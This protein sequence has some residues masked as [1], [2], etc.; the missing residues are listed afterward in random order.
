[1][2]PTPTEQLAG[3]ARILADAVAPAVTDPYAARALGGAV[4]ALRLLAEGGQ[5]LGPFL[6]WD[7][8]QTA[9]VLRLAG[10][11]VEPVPP[12]PLADDELEAH[13]HRLREALEQAL[14]S[15]A[16]DEAAH[17]ALV[18]LFRERAARWPL[19]ARR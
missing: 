16:S 1:M 14:P 11:A 13:H 8:E 12:G 5:D 2:R 3:I 18:R 17:E 19:G 9:V 7:A 15:V 6:R 4:V 10:V